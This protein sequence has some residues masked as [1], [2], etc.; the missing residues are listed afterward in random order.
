[1][2]L[3]AVNQVLH[4]L[5]QDYVF[6]GGATVSLYATGPEMVNAVRPTD[7]VDII[8]QDNVSKKE[9]KMAPIK[10]KHIRSY[11]CAHSLMRFSLPAG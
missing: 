4:G 11:G 2:R 1:M 7:D 8:I 3:K 6:V 10:E 9:F 5:D